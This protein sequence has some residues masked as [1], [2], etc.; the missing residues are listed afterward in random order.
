M[1]PVNKGASPYTSIREYGDA[2]P[3]LEER[4]G[5]Y[6]SYCGAK[7]DHAPEIEHVVSK[8]KRGDKTEWKNLLL[9]CKYCNT[10]KSNHTTPE[11][12]NDYLWPDEN[13]TELA[14]SYIGG[15]PKVNSQILSALDASGETAQKAENLYELV[16]LGN[17]PEPGDKDRRFRQRNKAFDDASYSL[18][19]WKKLKET[20]G[21][22]A[23]KDQIIRTAKNA[24]FFSVW[25]EVFKEEPEMKNALLEAFPGTETRFFDAD[26][27]VKPI[28]HVE[29]LEAATEVAT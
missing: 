4:I 17:V 2:L 27:N 9:A 3:Y 19:N 6:C 15:I 18:Q 29:E 28:L 26:G 7:I 16:K 20:D 13:N 10:R 25:M 24:V 14:Y 23:M 8:S 11:N 5:I 1:R 12:K 22:A 21:K